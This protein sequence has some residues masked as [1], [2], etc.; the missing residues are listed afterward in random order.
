M[1]SRDEKL[2][3]LK[4]ALQSLATNGVRGALVQRQVRALEAIVATEG[5]PG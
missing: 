3:C 5:D 4:E 1:A 2:K